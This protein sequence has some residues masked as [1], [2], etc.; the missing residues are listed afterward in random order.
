MDV[1]SSIFYAKDFYKKRKHSFAYMPSLGFLNSEGTENRY[2]LGL[3][4][5]YRFEPTR[6]SNIRVNISGNYI[7]THYLYDRHEYNAQSELVKQKNTKSNFGPSFGLH[8]SYD[9][10][11][12]KQT[13]FALSLGY[14]RIK[15]EDGNYTRLTE[16]FSSSISLGIICK[17]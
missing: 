1:G 2:I 10:F 14:K 9:I 15:L 8:Y 13:S 12:I 5:Q 6:R 16:G 7:L 4:V 11:R 3:G 17:F